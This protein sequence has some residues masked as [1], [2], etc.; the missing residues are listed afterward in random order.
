MALLV[1]AL[2]VAA[3][4]SIDPA[5]PASAGSAGSSTAPPASPAA[6]QSTTPSGSAVTAS[7]SSSSDPTELT[8]SPAP[9]PAGS[10][11]FSP[12][13][14]RVTLDLDAT[15]TSVNRFD[16]FF[17]VEQDIGTP[18]VIAVQ[19]ARPTGIAGATQIEPADQP[20]DA[21]RILSGN[22]DLT[23]V[24]ESDSRLGGLTGRVLVVENRSGRHAAVMSVG[25]G[26]LG[27]DSGRKLWVAFF[28]TPDGLVAVMVG[29]SIAK[30]DVALRTAEPVLESIA[31][32]E[33]ASPPP[34]S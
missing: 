5:Q 25:P 1:A 33:L 12:F 28:A 19:V 17:D 34:S 10:Y 29:G 21:G 24:E 31:F 14:P 22:R 4:G 13:R 9:L 27:I 23:I 26:V 15:W 6:S 16:D 8:S 30:W 7:P 20:R 2:V 3:C 18:D 32:P 11:T